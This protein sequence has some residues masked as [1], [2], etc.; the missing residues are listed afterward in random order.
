M[1]SSVRI[2]ATL[3]AFT[4]LAACHSDRHGTGGDGGN[5]NGDSGTQSGDGGGDGTLRCSS[6][7]QNVTDAAGNVVT[8]CPPAQGCFAGACIEAC[9]AAS[10][11]KGNV[12]CDFVVAT[13]AFFPGIAPPCFAV[14]LA[15]NWSSA[16]H[17]N[18]MRGAMSY[19]ATK[20]ARIATGASP[21]ASTWTAVPTTGLPPGQVAVLF[22][23]SDPSSS[24]LGNSLACPVTQAENGVTAV[25]GTDV[26]T[27]FHITTD[28]PVSAYDILPYGGAL[29][30]LPAAELLLP[31]SA[32]GTNYVAV[33]PPIGDRD[34]GP[35]WGQVVAAQ[36]NTTIKVNPT[37]ALTGNG[38]TMPAAPAGTATSFTL[39]A[40]QFLQ[41]EDS[42]EI[43]G[44]VISSDKPVVF[45]GGTGYLCLSDATSI[46]GG[47]DSAHQTIPPVAALGSEYVGAPY[48]TRRAS[49]QPESIKYRFVGAVD[50]TVLNFDPAVA[51]APPTLK[52]GYVADFETATPFTV[53]SQDAAHPFY[54][55]QLMTG[56][57]VTDGSRPGVSPGADN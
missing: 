57:Q 37:V 25:V 17:I 22:M 47:C 33:V 19:D 48:T 21:D 32:W 41:W 2:A 24:N 34:G 30:Y 44:S 12:G 14:F 10:M 26:G 7:L 49:M 23:N 35:R 40:G 56:A 29:S 46:G 15:N 52:R 38:G 39:N 16:I 43:S 3:L 51:G 11:T 9:S 36:D 45:T 8:M 27:A 6:D 53:S 42:G 31:T 13:P 20:F 50:G 54:V 18:V 1:R 5:G 55:A 28:A 4:F